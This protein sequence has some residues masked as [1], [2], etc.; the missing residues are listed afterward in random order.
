MKEIN[1]EIDDIITSIN[2]GSIRSVKNVDWKNL[3]IAAH[4]SEH[5]QD[6][7]PFILFLYAILTSIHIR[8]YRVDVLYTIEEHLNE[9]LQDQNT[10][11]KELKRLKEECRILASYF[12]YVDYL[13][14]YY[15]EAGR[16]YAQNRDKD[17]MEV[18][19]FIFYKLLCQPNEV[20]RYFA[21]SQTL[22][23]FMTHKTIVPVEPLTMPVFTSFF[24]DKIIA[25]DIIEFCKSLLITE[26]WRRRYLAQQ[27][28][29]LVTVRDFPLAL[30]NAC[31]EEYIRIRLEEIE[32]EFSENN[33]RLY[34]P[35]KQNY[36]NELYKREEQA[37]NQLAGI[38]QFKGSQ[39]YSEIWQPTT[40]DVLRM[41]ELFLAY[42][43]DRGLDGKVINKHGRRI[44]VKGDYIKRLEIGTQIIGAGKI[45]IIQSSTSPS[46]SVNSEST[47]VPT[48]AP[49]P[50]PAPNQEVELTD[51]KFDQHLQLFKEAM[52][53]MQD[54][55][56]S[57]IMFANAIM[58]AY[59]W[60]AVLRLGQDIGQLGG[61][62]DLTALMQ[63]GQ[64]K[65][66]P[67]NPQNLNPYKK[68]IN[69]E[70]K[71][72]NWQCSHA[73]YEGTFRKFKF[74]ADATYSLYCAGCD[75]HHIKPFGTG[76]K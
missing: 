73:G 48:P 35:S 19:A 64:F 37:Y 70:P 50:T 59:E 10:N 30:R 57:E 56:Y 22:L 33:D 71:Y 43:K 21:F 36:K 31:F 44:L 53:K 40:P 39:A 5:S 74:I 61:Y 66:V 25:Q 29:P 69:A 42:L 8:S 38:A 51:G 2:N 72:P 4:Q 12:R 32:K 6:P 45:E 54:V 28:I 26:H 52:L 14:P 65:F 15:D 58:H 68:Y 67:A 27:P 24:N 60:Q 47:T 41:A 49:A 1:F 18:E 17:Q 76:R 13:I 62:T 16:I 3:A 23:A 63:G 7:L 75:L 20:K 9:Y 55:K 46:P 11:P 34:P